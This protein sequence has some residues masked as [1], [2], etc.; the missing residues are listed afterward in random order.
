MRGVS[1]EH[2]DISRQTSTDR[3]IFSLTI[4]PVGQ[5][6]I[7]FVFGNAIS[8]LYAACEL[9][10]L[11]FHAVQ[12]IVGEFA[13]VF[14]DF[15]LEDFPVSFD[16]VPVHFGLLYLRVELGCCDGAVPIV[17]SP[18]ARVSAGVVP[19]GIGGVVV[20]VSLLLPLVVGGV[21]DAVPP[22][23]LTCCGA[24]PIVPSPAA[25]ESCRLVPAMG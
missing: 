18:T 6:T 20:V 7:R 17:P 25:P 2:I 19:P 15:A 23:G 4:G 8:F 21:V 1:I 3:S 12:V 13:P 16:A 14:L 22:R 10:A 11:A 24:V 9:L 5:L